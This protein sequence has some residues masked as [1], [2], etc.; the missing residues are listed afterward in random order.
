M[1]NYGTPGHGCRLYAGRVIAIEPMIN[2]G[3]KD[4]VVKK[5]GW[6][7][8]TADGDLSAHY[9]HTVAITSDGPVLLTDVGE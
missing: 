5:D 8:V 6:T 3:T 1:P 9:E 2:R 7:V 4:V